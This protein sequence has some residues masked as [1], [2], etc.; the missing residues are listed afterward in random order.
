[1][2]AHEEY[3]SAVVPTPCQVLNLDLLPFSAGHI[4]HL[5][6]LGSVFVKGGE[7]TKD[8]LEAAVLICAQEFKQAS[9]CL[10]SPETENFVAKWRKK[11]AGYDL[12]EKSEAFQE[13]IRRGCLFPIHFSPKHDSAS[14]SITN[15]PAVHSVRCA[16]KHYFHVTD[17]EFWDMPW[18][19]AQWDYF[20][21]PVMEGNGDLVELDS[22]TAARNFAEEDFK[23][24]N[25]QLFNEDGTKKEGAWPS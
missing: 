25:P 3:F 18:A 6:R 11:I 4:I 14:V 17:S 22:L 5:H 16:L 12:A 24:A 23:R 10:N 7:V 1:M 13:Y 21:I 9:A 2:N 20:T 15:L 8:E 19:L